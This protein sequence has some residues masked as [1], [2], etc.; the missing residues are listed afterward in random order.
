MSLEHAA[1]MCNEAFFVE[2]LHPIIKKEGDI[3]S[4][5][6]NVI[7]YLPESEDNDGENSSS[8][9]VGRKLAK[10]FNQLFQRERE[11]DELLSRK[12]EKVS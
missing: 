2:L 4:N 9:S 6:E 3:S 10:K 11:R 7:Q 5:I 8:T 12:K 1:R